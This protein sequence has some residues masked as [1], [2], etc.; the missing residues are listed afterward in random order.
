MKTKKII[1]RL[2]VAFFALISLAFA[3]SYYVA[4]VV[5]RNYFP[6]ATSPYAIT[7]PLFFVVLS[8]VLVIELFA[9]SIYTRLAARR[10]E[11]IPTTTANDLHAD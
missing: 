6:Q 2:I 7:W 1:Y 8:L 3:F 9:T 4:F 5:N 11:P 10:K